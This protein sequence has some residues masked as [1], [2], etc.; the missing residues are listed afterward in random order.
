MAKVAS[1]TKWCA[2]V[3]ATTKWCAAVSAALALLVPGAKTQAGDDAGP[4]SIDYVID[5]WTQGTAP[6]VVESSWSHH[7]QIEAAPEQPRPRI[8][9]IHK[10]PIPAGQ[11]PEDRGFSPRPRCYASFSGI[12]DTGWIPPDPTLAVGPNHIVETVNS[13]VAWFDKSTGALQFA[14]PFDSSGSPGFFEGVGAG[15]FCF[16]PRCLYDDIAGRFVVMCAE[17]YSSTAFIDI[18]VSDDNDP[19][20]TWY[21]YQTDAVTTVGASTYWVDYPSLGF[22]DVGYYVTGNLFDFSSGGSGGAKYR[23][24]DKSTMLSGGTVA[25]TDLRDSGSFSVQAGEHHSTPNAPFFMSINSTTSLKLQ[26]IKTPITNPTLVTTTISVNT[27]ASPPDAPNLGGSGIDTLDGRLINLEH[28]AGKLVCGHGVE[29]NSN[30]KSTAR[31][32][33]VNCKTWPQSGSPFLKQSG[34]VDIGDK[35]SDTAA[36]YPALSYNGN[37]GIGMTFAYS[38]TNEYAGIAYATHKTTDT[39][40]VMTQIVRVQQ[41]LD[42]YSNFRWGDY[43]DCCPD[44]SDATKFWGVGE[45]TRSSNSWGTR[46]FDFDTTWDAPT[47]GILMTL[48]G[49][50]TTGGLSFTKG[51]I[52]RCDSGTAVYSMYFD[53]SDVLPTYPN[54]KSFALKPRSTIVMGF[55]AP[56]SI[57]RLTGGPNGT[58]VDPQDLVEFTPAT[59]GDFTSGAWSFYFDGSDVG[60]DTN[61]ENIDAIAFDGS[62]FP[63]L[64]F[65]GP[66]DVGGGLTGKD[67]DLVLFTP[68]T[69]GSA[70][71]GTWSLLFNGRDTDVKLGSP[72]E[73][74][75]GLDFDSVNSKLTVSTDGDFQV[76]INLTGHMDDLITFTFT[77]LGSNPAGTWALTF[78][79]STKGLIDASDNVEDIEILP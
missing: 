72:G 46:L 31:W 63:I 15:S 65:T 40:G 79:G 68:T 41:G 42:S 18:A 62:G 71:T 35:V 29:I 56:L 10:L 58:N 2:A 6:C 60:L 76:P 61:G 13:T 22:D 24:F 4:P 77:Q 78:D 67:E 55:G 27:F 69:L 64:S 53:L 50:K 45:F 23:I 54:V 16:D 52:V 48:Q 26:A 28:R 17:V 11:K 66:W 49:N 57:P 59:L 7:P 39:G 43:F 51:D 44:P 33:E 12:N 70:T 14:A 20:G 34:D 36:W 38:G 32:Y 8:V 5:D 3:S 21:A 74:V 37:G 19:N 47:T 9:P 25:Y 1:W 73:D 75:D 30:G